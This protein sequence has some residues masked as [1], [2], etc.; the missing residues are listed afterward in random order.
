MIIKADLF[1]PVE[2]IV[3][4]QVIDSDEDSFLKI[5][6][7]LAVPQIASLFLIQK[8]PDIYKDRAVH[9]ERTLSETIDVLQSQLTS[10]KI[11]SISTE[12]ISMLSSDDIS[13]GYEVLSDFRIE[14]LEKK[15]IDEQ[16]YLT[17]D[18]K[19][20]YTFNKKHYKKLYDSLIEIGNTTTGSLHTL[21]SEQSLI[22]R[23]IKAQLDDHMHV[24]GYAGTGKSLLINSI[25]RMLK[26]KGVNVL[27]L[28]QRRS[29]KDALISKIDRSEHVSVRTFYALA[30]ELIPKDWT[31]KT[32]MN[33]HQTGSSFAAMKDIAVIKHF[34]IMSSGQLSEHDI[35]KA[36]R[37]VLYSFCV[38]GDDEILV[39][40]IPSHYTSLSNEVTKQVIIHHAKELWKE[41]LLPTSKDIKFPLKGYHRIK[42]AALNHWSI[43]A[44]YTHILIDEC[45]DL[46]KP[47]LQVLDFSPQAVISL[48]D[49]Y[50]N[51][52]GMSQ[53]RS[54]IVRQREVIHS[55]RS[56][57]L[58]ENIINPIIAIHPGQT[59]A[60]FIG[61]KL[62]KLKVTYY[63]KPKVSDRPATILVNDWWGLFEW[64]QRIASENL[65]LTL[66][67]NIEKLNMFVSDC[68]ELYNNGIS[69]RH[70]ELFR[71]KSWDKLASVYHNNLSFQHVDQMLRK[72]YLNKNWQKTQEKFTK[73][74]PHAYKLGQ[75]E[76]VRNHEFETVMVVPDVVRPV[77]QADL[78]KTATVS[79]AIYVAVTRA[80][81]HLILPKELRN[82]IEE[83]SAC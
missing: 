22:Y 9:I 83:I 15:V 56:G 32:N 65:Y 77:W 16:E 61:N 76:D 60:P 75:I 44:R 43:P 68:I 66:L 71:F 18:E 28:T 3:V 48:G 11:T 45:H 70:G 38:S 34:N 67:S 31:N 14:L 64:A 20:D 59:K 37:S 79:S 63:D 2:R 53:T 17:Q 57:S 1:L 80:T 33:M 26:R 51:L 19:W 41:I 5:V 27:I 25:V 49:E 69:P 47:M 74:N 8:L 39:K 23:E 62:T 35:V 24:Q 72:G 55:V 50:Q 10:N 36:V 29:Q 42:W 82:W 13:K 46:I 40:H 52:K 73:I 21:T 12:V 81:Q 78:N 58:I 4:E 6:S 30:Y 54:N 7:N